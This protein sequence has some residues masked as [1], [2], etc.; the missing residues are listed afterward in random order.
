[1]L[2]DIGEITDFVSTTK[3]VLQMLIEKHFPT[4]DSDD[5]DLFEDLGKMRAISSGQAYFT[6]GRKRKFFNT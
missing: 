2:Q 5:A 3:A 1:M 6:N 4:G